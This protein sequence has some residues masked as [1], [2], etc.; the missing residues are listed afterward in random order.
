MVRS[1]G[2][3]ISVRVNPVRNLTNHCPF[4]SL[5]NPTFTGLEIDN[6][7]CLKELDKLG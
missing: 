1:Q 5:P 7:S 2:L 4:H 3:R 6:L